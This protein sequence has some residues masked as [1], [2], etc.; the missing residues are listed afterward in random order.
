[1]I[2]V[3]YPSSTNTDFTKNGYGF[4]KDCISCEI[5]EELNGIYESVF[6]YPINGLHYSE[7]E[8]DMIV[9]MKAS[10]KSGNQLFRIYRITKSIKN[11]AKIYCQH[12]SYDLCLN[13]VSPFGLSNV[14]V[15]AALQER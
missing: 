6:T 3:L 15:S 10:E 1:M 2:P 12:I 13:V 7:I 9:K 4:L 5:T 14:G 8:P 11:T